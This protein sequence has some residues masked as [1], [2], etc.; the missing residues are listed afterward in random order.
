MSD[1]NES[2]RLMS[3][4][5]YIGIWNFE[6]TWY[7]WFEDQEKSKSDAKT[8][9]VGC[10]TPCCLETAINSYIQLLPFFDFY[11]SNISDSVFLSRRHCYTIFQIHIYIDQVTF[12][13]FKHHFLVIRGWILFYFYSKMVYV[14]RFYIYI[15][16]TIRAS[17]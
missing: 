7:I 16:H 12:I 5:V 17:M 2:V 4:Y 14:N 3:I 9:L 1:W 11:I 10:Q 6:L 8:P 15:L 13:Y